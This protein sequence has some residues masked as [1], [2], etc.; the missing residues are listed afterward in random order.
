MTN[1]VATV[2]RKKLGGSVIIP[3]SKSV[4]HRALICACLRGKASKIRCESISLDI[5]ATIGCLRGLGYDITIENEYIIVHEGRQSVISPVL[6]CKE[7]GSTFRFILPI[8]AA[9]GCGA[10]FVGEG[11]LGKRP[12]KELFG[13]L[14]R[15][16]V[17]INHPEESVLPCTVSGKC[18]CGRFSIRGDISSQ[19][20]TGILLSLP[21]ME[22]GEVEIV[23]KIESK[24]YID[25]TL[26][27][28]KKF[29]F[30]MIDEDGKLVYNGYCETDFVEYSVEGDFSN[31]AFFVV[32]G[33][34][35]AKEKLELRG[36][37]KDSVQG[38]KAIID[39]MKSFG[40][41]IVEGESSIVVF[42]SKLHGT[43]VDVTDT[44]DLAPIIA[45][46]SAAASGVTFIHGCAR[47]RAKESD[48]IES[49]ITLINSL[50]G[51]A[52]VEGDTIIVEGSG[53]LRGGRVD[54]F[55]D[56]R[57]A[58]S[59]AICSLICENE[60]IIDGAEAVCKSFP[61]FFE[62]FDSLN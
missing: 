28:M 35:G 31:A 27:V 13:E 6:D 46:A 34:I 50:G 40:G 44:P 16:G 17:T 7:S 57:I 54:A 10:T 32:G 52:R 62:I 58:M 38:D 29:G 33:L 1:M 43:T 55:G 30:S 53:S 9:L 14:E 15:H 49:T 3:P 61:S 5:E 21:I 20:I 19:Y 48:R 22:K 41:N 56:H 4:A 23:G 11:R 51:N 12:M 59:A 25:I 42:P 2:K 26:D 36:L 37:Y 45:V 39:I 60:V 8:V 18:D 47:L 24:P